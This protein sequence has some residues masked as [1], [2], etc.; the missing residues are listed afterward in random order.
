VSEQWIDFLAL[1]GL[2]VLATA[3]SVAFND[4]V[5]LLGGAMALSWNLGRWQMH[6]RMVAIVRQFR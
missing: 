5:G 1:L 4:P 6:G 3:V 2:I